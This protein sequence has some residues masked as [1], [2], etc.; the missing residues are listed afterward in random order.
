[1]EAQILNIYLS[2]PPP[3]LSFHS[4]VFSILLNGPAKLI[5]D[6]IISIRIFITLTHIEISRHSIKWAGE[7]EIR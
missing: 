3:L 6:W 2:L 7:G 5:M 4:G 1:M